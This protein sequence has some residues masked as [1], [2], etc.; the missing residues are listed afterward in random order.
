MADQHNAPSGSLAW[1]RLGSFLSIVPLGVWTVNHLWKNL[2]AFRGADA[3]ERSV[4]Q[5]AHPVAEAATLIIVL[6]P[7]LIHT[8]WGIQRLFS[9]RPNDF[10]YA[11]Y[12]NLKY[13]LQR[14]AAIGVLLFLG[15]HLWLAMIHP[16]LVL[17]HPE[18]F[19]DIAYEMRFHTPTLVVY[20]LGTLAVCY[21]LA[22]GIFGF[23]WTWGIAAGRPSFGR[24]NAL[25]TITFVV[26]MCLSWGAIY[27]LWS[28]GTGYSR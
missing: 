4:T 2:A 15:A 26:L 27:A 7:L 20:L 28:A 17:G 11:Y 10:A 19:S 1:A 13:L 9:F 12:D 21:H 16:R 14:L 23:V 18:P 5:Y 3:W 25:A 8:L 22:N 6:V 24:I